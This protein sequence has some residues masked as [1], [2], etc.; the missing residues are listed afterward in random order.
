MERLK[1]HR[2]GSLDGPAIVCLHGFL[3]R[4]TDWMVFA[5]AW[6]SENPGWRICLVE[7]PG[8]DG[9]PPC[10]VEELALR[11]VELL[12]E[13]GMASC[14][15]AGYSMGGRLALHA[16]LRFPER[17]PFFVGVSTTAGLEDRKGRRE[18]DLRLAAQLRSSDA[19]DYRN[20]LR[21]WWNLPVF[22]SP[23]KSPE[24]LDRFL[25]SRADHDPALLAECLELWSPGVLEPQWDRLPVYPGCAILAAG[26]SDLK[27]VEL[28]RRM[29]SAFRIAEVAILSN[30]GHRLLEEDSCGLA[31]ELGNWPPLLR[32]LA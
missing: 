16:A 3:G 21:E 11:L 26:A 9:R 18:A 31:R 27:Y 23:Q 1:F 4:A 10:G 28:S 7:L 14:A 6:L 24:A 25:A 13:E 2:L 8:H 30:C 15:L 19:G 22:D 17:F 20:F 29:A 5:E 12:D 32:R